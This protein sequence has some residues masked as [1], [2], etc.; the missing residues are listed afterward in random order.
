[1]GSDPP[2]LFDAY[3]EVANLCQ[4]YLSGQLVFLGDEKVLRLDKV[5]HSTN[6]SSGI[7][8]ITCRSPSRADIVIRGGPVSLA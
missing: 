2:I 3:D 7:E 4:S 1:M 5:F 8:Q 6:T